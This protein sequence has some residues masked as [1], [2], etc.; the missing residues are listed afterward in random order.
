M[1]RQI[2]KRC[3]VAVAIIMAASVVRAQM[4]FP[5][6]YPYPA[7]PA[8]AQG[9]YTMANEPGKSFHEA[10]QNFLDE[11][12]KVAAADIRKGAAYLKMEKAAAKKELHEVIAA[13]E[14]DLEKLAQNV[15]QGTVESARE[16]DAVF[17]RAHLALAG[18][19]SARA[20]EAWVK[21]EEVKT[22][23][24]LKA[25]LAHIKNAYAWSGRI[26][27]A[28]TVAAVKKSRQTADKL[29]AGTGAAAEE[30][31]KALETTGREIEKLG[32]EIRQEKK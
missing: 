4:W 5:D 9:F 3:A 22:G 7:T 21:K 13:S 24:L 27:D 15:E 19:Y 10:R 25:A 32:A 20:S 2:L 28:T 6:P 11:E 26:M 16:L 14:R 18:S 12:A 17:A 1:C 30:A 23:Q 8:P 29:I 31:G